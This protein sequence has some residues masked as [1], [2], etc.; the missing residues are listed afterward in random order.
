VESF[1]LRVWKGAVQRMTDAHQHTEIELNLI[2]RGWMTYR[3]GARNITLKTGDW[4][5]FWGALPHVLTDADA[6]THCI[7]LTLPL[8]DFLRFALNEAFSRSVLHGDPIRGRDATDT[9]LFQRWAQDWL[10]P[11]AD[12]SRIL[13]LELEARLRRLARDLETQPRPSK[14]RHDA[15][16]DRAAQ[17]AQFITE[18]HL[19]PLTVTEIAKAAGLNPNYAAGLFK[20]SFGMTMLEYLT[21]HR[22]AHAQ[23]LLVTTDRG[24]LDI[25]LESGFTSSS[26]FYVAFER[27]TGRTPLE[28]RRGV[29]YEAGNPR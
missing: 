12:T 7:W 3:F 24:V 6:D 15:N 9:D 2:V 14:A 28:Y 13:Q 29:R 27:A 5:L 10:E 26:R 20:R 1:G 21:Q 19:E 23:R 25:A 4:L 16:P 18:H 8:A 22:V 11:H 17:L